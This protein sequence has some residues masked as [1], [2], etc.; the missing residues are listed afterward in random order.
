[1]SAISGSAA[2][3]SARRVSSRTTSALIVLMRRAAIKTSMGVNG[4][5]KTGHWAAQ[6]QATGAAASGE[7]R[8]GVARPEFSARSV[9]DLIGEGWRFFVPGFARGDS[10]R[11]SSRGC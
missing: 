11:R 1:M 10:C 6:N 2:T 5:A 4:G 7:R 9:G 8:E 3:I